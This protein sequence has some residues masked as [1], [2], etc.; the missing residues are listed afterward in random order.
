MLAIRGN[1]ATE[2]TADEFNGTGATV[3]EWAI[4]AVVNGENVAGKT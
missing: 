2:G 1:R 3:A 4:V